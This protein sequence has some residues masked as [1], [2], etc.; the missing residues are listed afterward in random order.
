MDCVATGFES[1]AGLQ[2]E[3]QEAFMWLRMG[4]AVGSSVGS[5][6][7]WFAHCVT[8]GGAA[9]AVLAS[10]IAVFAP[11]DARAQPVNTSSLK[12]VL[13]AAPPAWAYPNLGPN[14]PA[15]P[16]DGVKHT[17]EGSPYAFTMIELFD[18][19]T[20]NDWFPDSHPPMPEVVAR[21]RK[22]DV[23][24]CGMCHYPNGQGRP[25]NSALAGLTAN[26]IVQQVKDLQSGA[27]RSSSPQI[28]PQLRMRSTAQHVSDEELNTAAAYFASMKYRP[29]IKVIETDRVPLTQ[30]V[31]G[32]MWA[33]V[34]G[35]ATEPIGHRI[36][37]VPTD[38]RRT[39]LRDPRSGFTAYVPVGSIARGEVIAK[40]GAAK[41]VPCVSCHGPD[42]RGL[43][44]FPRWRDVLPSICFASCL[45]SVKA[46]AQEPVPRS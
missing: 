28:G 8:R 33:V 7:H 20:A 12:N 29:W 23:R 43:G 25:E 38:Y 2:I 31:I 1:G 30:V 21:G 14:P 19:F 22:P 42:L 36:I 34:P 32:S 40:S 44:D 9:C 4:S 27:R 37:E 26:Y 10:C 41:G 17:L 18:L 46:L 11:T 15:P 35:D 3:I 24:A 6:F 16:N 13:P 45:T 39:E 5:G